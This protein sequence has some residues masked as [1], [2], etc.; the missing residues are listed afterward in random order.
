[1]NSN[2]SNIITELN[3]TIEETE[4][5]ISLI[6]SID[7]TKPINEY[8][9]HRICE[10][11]LKDSELLIVLIKN[12]FPL[13]ENIKVRQEYIVF[14]M[15]GF[16]I[17]I[18]TT[19]NDY[20]VYIDTRWYEKDD[21]EPTRI[22]S[23]NIESLIKYFNSVDNKEGWYEC[24]KHRL[25]YG[26]TCKKWKLFFAWWFKY[27]WKDPH[28]EDFEEMKSK[29]EMDYLKKVN[30]YSSTRADMRAKTEKLLFELLPLLNKFSKTHHAIRGYTIEEL[31]KYENL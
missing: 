23:E 16:S 13:A 8:Q 30:K 17:Q 14:D 12:T 29:Q 22:Y 9:W 6:K 24:A 10:T 20:G 7:F 4:N 15:M 25:V 2:V 27:R 28:R 31:K 26:D 1:M 19:E 11:P 3:K 5:K 18:P 21:G